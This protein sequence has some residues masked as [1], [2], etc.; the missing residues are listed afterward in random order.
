MP[1]NAGDVD[2]GN[3]EYVGVDI[4]DVHSINAKENLKAKGLGYVVEAIE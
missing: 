1:V 4:N 3:L 2:K